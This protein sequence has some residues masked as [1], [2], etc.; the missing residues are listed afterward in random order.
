MKHNISIWIKTVIVSA[1]LVFFVSAFMGCAT[2]EKKQEKQAIG[3]PVKENQI[4]EITSSESMETVDVII[5]GDGLLTYTAVKQPSPAGVVLYFPKTVFINAQNEYPVHHDPVDAVKVVAP[6]D[7]GNPLRIEIALNS[8]APYEVARDGNHLKV[9]FPKPMVLKEAK[10]EMA[11]KEEKKPALQERSRAATQLH[12]VETKAIEKGLRIHLVADGPISDYSAFTV[13]DPARIVFDVPGLKSPY[14]REKQIPVESEWVKQIRYY[15]YADKIRVVLDVDKSRLPSYAADTAPDGLVIRVGD[16]IQKTAPM[17]KSDTTPKPEPSWVNRI[18][19]LSEDAGKSTVIIGTTGQV[20]Y[21]I[22]KGSEKNLLLT[23]QPANLPDYRKQPLITTRFESAVNRIIPVQ[24]DVMKDSAVISIELRE[25]V[26]YRVEQQENLVLVHF[27]AS[28]I[29]PKPLE[30]AK[31]PDWKKVMEESASPI[32][33]EGG[34]PDKPAAAYKGEKIALDFYETDIKNVF[35]ILKEVSSKNF[36]IDN[37]VSGKVTLSFDKPVPWDQVMDLVLKMNKL[38][39][40]EEGEIIRIAKLDTLVDEEKKRQT[41]ADT[42]PLITE[43]IFVN[44]A[45]AKEEVLPL[46][47]EIKSER[48]KVS[49]NER[50]NQ[51]I[52]TDVVDRIEKAKEIVKQVDKVTPQVMIEARIVEAGVDFS[53]SIGINWSLS[54]G[55]I[56]KKFLG[57]QYDY[58]FGFN[59]PGAGTNNI[60]FSFTKFLGSPLNLDIQLSAEESNGTVKILSAPKVATANNKEALISQGLEYPYLERDESGLATV[61]FKNIDL[62]LTVTPQIT[63]DNRISIAVKIKKDDIDRLI[64]TPTGDV[65]ALSTHQAETQLLVNDGDTIVIGGIMKNREVRGETGFPLLSKIPFLGW[66]FKQRADSS[67]RRELIVFIT[68]KIVRLES[69]ELQVQLKN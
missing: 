21:D 58:D 45:K 25:W 53:R 16:Q 35:R 42:R 67:E 43:Y 34:A 55:P 20:T 39:K 69:G 23:L 3:E 64:G 27:E 18:D 41:R 63:N 31:L 11:V 47:N 10:R 44:Y 59:Y 38:G 49:V 32:A 17:A 36:A 50:T 48:G 61:K 30:T 19:F 29:P 68:P 2:V 46:V 13:D 52:M 12:S 54:G 28:A 15:G 7:K 4:T 51:I 26:P 33:K 22:K 14:K 24:T 65:P 37:D 57:G 56:F 60:G 6:L 8:D 40:I 9:S 5:K 66:L 62:K 1:S